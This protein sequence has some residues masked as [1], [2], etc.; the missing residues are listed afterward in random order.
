MAN[1]F[2]RAN[3]NFN[4]NIWSTTAGGA[5]GASV[6]TIGDNAIANTF[7]IQITANQIVSCDGLYNSTL[8]SAT[9]GGT[10]NLNNGSTVSVAAS[11]INS[12]TAAIACVTLSGTNSTTINGD[13]I[14][15]TTTS[16]NG[17]AHAVS[18]TSSGTLSINGNIFAGNTSSSSF[19]NGLNYN[20]NGGK[21]IIT[22]DVYGG[23]TTSNTYAIG[24]ALAGTGEV[25]ITGNAYGRNPTSIS[26]AA[27]S[28]GGAVN[29]TFTGNIY[30]G[31]GAT[32]VGIAIST[33]GIANLICSEIAG[34]SAGVGISNSSNNVNI[35]CASI[36]AGGVAG[37][38]STSTNFRVSGNLLN[39]ANGT[40][41]IY[42][43]S[44]RI[45]PIPTNGYIRYARNGTG[46]G[47]D[48]WLYQYTTDSLSA[49]SMP[50]VSAV[51][52][53]TTF[54]NGT[55]TGTC[56]IPS[57]VSVSFGVPVDNTTGT[58]ILNPSDV[59]SVSIASLSAE[60][61][62]GNRLKNSATL[63]GVGHLVASFNS[64]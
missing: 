38:T 27:I 49:F 42:A 43:P 34:G 54:A 26:N 9:A 11:G 16:S 60:G 22:G 36:R 14:P 7:T 29:L 48:A 8:G 18:H 40:Q 24:V 2:A 4:D 20:G 13:I 37:I 46:V 19:A 33:S 10:F 57:P 59:F 55:L 30:G 3:G 52:L 51:R 25:T 53:G 6:P 44:Y 31:G 45:D 56:A 28:C 5:V 21:V 23:A 62:L 64:N 50:P 32:G 39:A 35:V 17:G 61:T 58:A 47:S 12:G 41:A 1:R 63:Q 15:W